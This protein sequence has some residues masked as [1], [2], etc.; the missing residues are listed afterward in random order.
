MIANFGVLF[1]CAVF[2][3]HHLES[4]QIQP[5]DESRGTV[6][7]VMDAIDPTTESDRENIAADGGTDEDVAADG[8][9]DEDRTDD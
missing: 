3:Q 1:L 9:V 2:F 5:V 6:V 7:D 4:T 8:G